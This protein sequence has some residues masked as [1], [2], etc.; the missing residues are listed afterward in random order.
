MSGQ[1]YLDPNGE[2]AYVSDGDH[3]PGDADP[4]MADAP[5]MVDFVRDRYD[6]GDRFLY[7][8]YDDAFFESVGSACPGLDCC[9]IDATLGSSPD[10][11][12]SDGES[13]RSDT[14]QF[15][16][17]A[18]SVRFIHFDGVLQHLVGRDRGR[19]KRQVIAALSAA[20]DAL[21]EDGWVLV[22]ERAPRLRFLPD[23]FVAKC[24]FSTSKY[25]SY[26]RSTVDPRVVAGQPTHCLYTRPELRG[27]LAMAGFEIRDV[28]VRQTQDRASSGLVLPR[29][30]RPLTYFA[31]PR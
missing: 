6:T 12:D 20:K 5:P 13:L 3:Q 23:R 22:T 17:E 29:V 1:E 30:S 8:G 31:T 21:H 18:G 11:Q 9:R 28:D 26:P 25:A 16:D 14:F 19:S 10:W 27:M 24:L 4:T 2:T 15:A 7:I